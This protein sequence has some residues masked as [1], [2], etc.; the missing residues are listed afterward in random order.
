MDN[1]RS[2]FADCNN[3]GLA[4]DFCEPGMVAFQQ[5][6][7]HWRKLSSEGSEIVK[8]VD[9]NDWEG[10]EFERQPGTPR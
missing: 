2:V 9:R 6:D 10:G 7:N 1:Y 8:L 4:G 5:N 3:V